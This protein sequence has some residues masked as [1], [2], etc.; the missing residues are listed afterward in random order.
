MLSYALSKWKYWI[1][2]WKTIP[3]HRNIITAAHHSKGS[4]HTLPWPHHWQIQREKAE[5][6]SKAPLCSRMIEPHLRGIQAAGARRSQLRVYV[7]VRVT[8]SL[9]FQQ[10]QGRYCWHLSTPQFPTDKKIQEPH[11]PTNHCACPTTPP[12]KLHLT[13]FHIPNLRGFFGDTRLFK[14]PVLGLWIWTKPVYWISYTNADFFDWFLIDCF[15]GFNKHE[16]I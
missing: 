16:V 13:V 1:Q 14:M 5:E 15:N 4:G 10:Q 9:H 2:S 8:G 11:R 3:I 6:R 12:Q 7:Y